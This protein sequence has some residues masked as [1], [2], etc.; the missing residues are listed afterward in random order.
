MEFNR[1]AAADVRIDVNLLPEPYFGCREA[2]VVVLLLNPA[3]GERTLIIIG[4]QN[5]PMLCAVTY[6]AESRLPISI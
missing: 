6:P 2:P 1:L 3:V 5:S 4:F